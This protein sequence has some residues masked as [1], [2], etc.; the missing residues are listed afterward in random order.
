VTA[1]A[2]LDTSAWARLRDG[3]L[4]PGATLDALSAG[5]LG[6][7][8]PLLLEMRFSA[9]DAT[10]F[11]ELAEELGALPL[12]PLTGGAVRRAVVA[13]AELAADRRVS[14]R[15]KAIDLLVAAAAD[16]HH[17]AVL[18]YDHDYDILAAHTSLTFESR[19][20]AERGSVG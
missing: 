1:E 10:T 16:E 5:R 9:R 19:W 8:E 3:R 18:H 20:I 2:L 17:V 14:H 4:D 12:L 11:R 15:V 13:Q 7:C 6:V